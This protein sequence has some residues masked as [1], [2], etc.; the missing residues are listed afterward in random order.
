MKKIYGVF[1]NFSYVKLF[2]KKPEV[3]KKTSA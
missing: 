2:V 1:S 3:T